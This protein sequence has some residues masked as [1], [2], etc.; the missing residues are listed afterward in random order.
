MVTETRHFERPS[1]ITNVVTERNNPE[2][3]TPGITFPAYTR[4]QNKT[5][6]YSAIAG[7][8]IAYYWLPTF[9]LVN[10]YLYTAS[11][12]VSDHVYVV[13]NLGFQSQSKIAEPQFLPSRR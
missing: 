10:I 7:K 13:K 12:F 11:L 1:R 4:Q 9:A 8:R 6:A 2:E 5:K 3:L